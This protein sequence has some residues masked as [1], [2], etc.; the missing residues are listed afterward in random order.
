VVRDYQPEDRDALLKL[1]ARLTIGVAPWREPGAVASAVREWV[2]GSIDSAVK[3][4]GS[5]FVAVDGDEV[6]GFVSCSERRHFAGAADAYIGELVTA[7]GAEGRGVGRAMLDRAEQ[8]ARERG[9]ERITLETGARNT[10]ALR[11]YE[12]LGWEPE[13]VRLSKSLT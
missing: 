11:L 2:V 13:D 5:V 9:Y 10:R 4:R 1:A 12:H 3:G 6:V 7:A 8:W